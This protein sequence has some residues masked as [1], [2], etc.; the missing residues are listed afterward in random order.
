MERSKILLIEDNR[1]VRWW[2]SK[3]LTREGFQVVAPPSVDEALRLAATNRFDVLVSDWRLPDGQDGFKVLTA[4]RQAFPRII[5]ILI[6]AEADAELTE[7]ALGAGFDR[8]I[9][10]PM[11]VSQIVEAIKSSAA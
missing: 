10:K 8:V 1:L 9:P 6:S 5:S 4:V 2:M 7:R 3:C 11:E